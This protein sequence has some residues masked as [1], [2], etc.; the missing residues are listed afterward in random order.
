MQSEFSLWERNLEGDVIPALRELGIGLVPFSP[1]G[2]GFL[3]GEVKRAEDY[4]EGDFRRNDP[5]YQGENYDANMRAVG[6]VRGIADRLGAIAGAGGAWLG[7]WHRVTNIVP[8]PGTKR[9][10]RLEQ[11]VG[12][13]ADHADEGRSRGTRRRHAG[14]RHRRA[15]LWREDD[16]DDRSLS[17]AAAGT[18]LDAPRLGRTSAGDEVMIDA[19]GYSAASRHSD[20]KRTAFQCDEPGAHDVQIAIEFCGV[21][22]SDIHQ[23]RNEWGNTVYPCMPGHELVGRVTRIGSGR[24]QARG[25]RHGRCRLHDRQLPRVRGVPRRRRELLRWARTAGSRPITARWSRV[26]KPARTC[27]AATTPLAATRIR[28]SSSEDFVLKIPAALDPRQAAP[29]LCAGVTTYSPL[30]HWGVKA[31]AIRS[32]SSASAASATWRSSSR[33]P[34][35]PM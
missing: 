9:R 23:A 18:G 33:A 34:W 6:V 35:G 24:D 3:T 26:R 19:L 25:R 31:P 16:G 10:D 28:R 21:C 13:A 4:E 20:L 27:M 2:R 14:R 30:K 8:I 29:I 12:A 7:C 22:H 15:T 5:R 11:N 17:A 1:L 32:A